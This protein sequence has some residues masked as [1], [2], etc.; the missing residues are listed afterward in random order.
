VP[1]DARFHA[2]H[3][4]PE[5]GDDGLVVR[6]ATFGATPRR[7]HLRTEPDN[8]ERLVPLEPV[9]SR[10]AWRLWQAPLVPV[11]H[12][13]VTRY[14]FRFAF[15]GSQRWLAAD[16]LHASVPLRDVHFAYLPSYRPASWIW[17]GVVYQVF[18]DRFRDGDPTNNVR[19]G[20]YLY[21]GK[22]V[23][24]RSWH[25]LPT[26]GMG[27]R[28]FFGGDLDGVR[29]ALPYLEE[30]GASVL[31]LNPIFLSPSSHKYD[32]V[33]YER[34]DPHLGGE[35]AFERLV[36]A[37]RERGM[38][39][40]LDA[41]VNHT[42]ER[43]AWL[44]SAETGDHYV[45]DDPDDRASYRG[46]AGVRTLPVLDF[47]SPGVQEKIYAGDEAILRRWL[48]P[49]WR[50]DGWRLDV[51]HM[52]GEGA[53]ARR[54]HDHV[55]AIRAAIREERD[56]A[57]VLGEHFF[58][59]I[60]W[61]Q[62]DQEDG[63]MNYDGFLRPMLGFWAGIDFRGDP[64]ELDACALDAW[65][66]RV[67]ARLPHPIALSQ[68]N[69]LDSHDVPRFLTRVGGDARA[70]AAAAHAL[71]T[72]VGVPSIYYGDEIGLEG[73]EDPDCRRPF[74][75]DRTLW[76][77]ELREVYRRLAWLRRR[78]P[79]LARGGYLTLLAHGD[80]FAYARILGDEAVVTLLHR[81]DRATS[82]TLPVWATGTTG[83]WF[84]ALDGS[85]LPGDELLT[86]ALPP[87][88]GR[89]LVT[90]RSWLEAP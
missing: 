58:E 30:L 22:P 66:G 77:E 21:D 17:G 45:F 89:T 32:T 2:F 65:M 59:A 25:E 50:I 26:R 52:L 69:L 6:V 29:D 43:H 86:V 80:V 33:D 82:V 60:P 24:A 88:S 38:R 20:A 15:S 78:A 47:A 79:P 37:L 4:E 3:V 90:S 34:I 16:G 61:L 83:R 64:L 12:D 68:L 7:A 19:S 72:Y 13:P 14:A 49:P 10:G 53:G 85:S 5:A 1:P 28:E 63:A 9:A 70:L 40:V 41:V 57:Y 8:E 67:R 75:W 71:F 44:G 42:S 35:E 62:G 51:I 87:R 11:D 55:R 73:G 48:K 74:P 84:D 54:N 18:P 39:I 56:D 36:G 46:W 81:G 31:Y 76:N 23:V 27:A